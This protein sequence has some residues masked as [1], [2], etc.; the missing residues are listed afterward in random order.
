MEKPLVIRNV[1]ISKG[2][3][4]L[5]IDNL[6]VVW[7]NKMW[8]LAQI[9]EVCLNEFNAKMRKE[10]RIKFAWFPSNAMDVLQPMD[11]GIIYTFKSHYMQYLMQSL[12]NICVLY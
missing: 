9:M 12:I 6:I 2:F 11:I 1:A 10:N 3:K 8:K 7:R 4:N 5:K